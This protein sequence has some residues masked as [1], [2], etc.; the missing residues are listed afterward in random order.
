MPTW[1]GSTHRRIFWGPTPAQS[2]PPRQSLHAAQS[3]P[4]SALLSGGN[5]NLLHSEACRP[6]EHPHIV[7]KSWTLGATDFIGTLRNAG[8]VHPHSGLEPPMPVLPSNSPGDTQTDGKS[9]TPV[10]IHRRG[11]L[12]GRN[13]PF[14]RCITARFHSQVCTADFGNPYFVRIAHQRPSAHRAG[15]RLRYRPCACIDPLDNHFVRVCTF[16]RRSRCL[17]EGC[18]A[19]WL[20]IGRFRSNNRRCQTCRPLHLGNHPRSENTRSPLQF[21]ALRMSWTSAS[22][23]LATIYSIAG[24][25][26][27]DA[28]GRTVITAGTCHT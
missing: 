16:E 8:R 9:A 11:Q 25:A 4:I 7:A 23:T 18:S 19:H 6:F 24:E 15:K 1:Q 13:A 22:A 17:Q 20:H 14:R 10:S 2:R 21:I 28:T 12:S 5:T 27:A 3:W 26:C